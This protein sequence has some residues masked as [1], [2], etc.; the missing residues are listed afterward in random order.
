ME[1]GEVGDQCVHE[2]TCAGLEST[3]SEEITSLY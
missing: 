1:V 2:L 3:A